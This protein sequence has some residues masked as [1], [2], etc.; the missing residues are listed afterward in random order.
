MKVV[1]V[2]ERW[3]PK[4]LT[5]GRRIAEALITHRFPLAE[6]GKAFATA[7]DKTTGS[8]KVTVEA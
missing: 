4:A 1:E 3:A 5:A 6:I 7:A 8:I 2:D